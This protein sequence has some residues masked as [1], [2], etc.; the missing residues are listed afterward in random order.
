MY[1]ELVSKTSKTENLLYTKILK[2]IYLLE[3]KWNGVKDFS[4]RQ[5][6]QCRELNGMVRKILPGTQKRDH[7]IKKLFRLDL[8]AGL[9]SELRKIWIIWTGCRSESLSFLLSWLPIQ[10]G[11]KKKYA[12]IHHNH[13][14]FLTFLLYSS[15]PTRPN[16]SVY[17]PNVV[18][19]SLSINSKLWLMKARYKITCLCVCRPSRGRRDMCAKKAEGEA[20]WRSVI[21]ELG[22]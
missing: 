19:Q 13:M 14:K 2:T 18:L 7:E 10:P 20:E 17:K 16:C 8:S 12:L 22:S 9:Q 15:C 5:E 1:Q 4:K 6:Q 3:S 11:K 21:H